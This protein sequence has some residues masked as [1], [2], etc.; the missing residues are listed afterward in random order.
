MMKKLGARLLSA[1]MALSMLCGLLPAGALAAD[2]QLDDGTYIV[3]ANLYVPGEYN[4]ILGKNAY[5]T[6]ADVPPLQQVYNNAKLSVVDGEMTLAL[7][8]PN[9]VFTLQSISDGDNVK[10]VEANRDDVTYSDQSGTITRQG[11]VTDIK[12]KLLDKSGIYN[13]TDCKEFPTLLGMEWSVPLRLAVDFDNVEKV[14]TPSDDANV[15]TL[16]DGD[17]SVKV[18]STT[19]TADELDGMTLSAQKSTS[20]DSANAEVKANLAEMYDAE[21]VFE[22]YDISA[23]TVLHGNTQATVTVPT[24]YSKAAV[25]W[26][27]ENWIGIW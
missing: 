13:F 21:P 12:A 9:S 14:Y 23:D 5:L 10:I 25:C 18:E 22:V 11:R 3:T 2:E 8:I 27:E 6:N 20:E 17:V 15:K 26:N 4:S 24:S 1:V 19:M 7:D 16:T